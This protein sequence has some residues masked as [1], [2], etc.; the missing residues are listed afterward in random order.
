[1]DFFFALKSTILNAKDTKEFAYRLKH[2]SN[3]LTQDHLGELLLLLA[4][5][6]TPNFRHYLI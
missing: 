2:A 1:M 4:K 6:N 3:K 5:N